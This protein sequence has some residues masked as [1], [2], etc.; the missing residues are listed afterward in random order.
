MTRAN[1]AAR[2]IGALVWEGSK[3]YGGS[4]TESKEGVTK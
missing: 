4:R 2:Q 3:G 1:S